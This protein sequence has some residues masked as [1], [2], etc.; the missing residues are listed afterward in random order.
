LEF[1]LLCGLV[2][3]EV[4]AGRDL[5]S[6]T[7]RKHLQRTAE[8]LVIGKWKANRDP[9]E[10]DD[11]EARQARGKPQRQP[12]RNVA[13]FE[14]NIGAILAGAR[15]CQLSLSLTK[16]SGQDDHGS[17]TCLFNAPLQSLSPVKSSRFIGAARTAARQCV[18]LCG[19]H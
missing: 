15:G 1:L 13:R 9:E 14:A 4:V 8:L 19:R 6:R 18:T 17:R 3:R 11:D 16:H 10:H 12:W 2:A 5:Q 7:G